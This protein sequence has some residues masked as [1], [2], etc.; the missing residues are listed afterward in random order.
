M[1]SANGLAAVIYKNATVPDICASALFAF[2]KE[3]RFAAPFCKTAF[4]Q[5]MHWFE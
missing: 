1:F 2:K 5:G 3:K 4:P